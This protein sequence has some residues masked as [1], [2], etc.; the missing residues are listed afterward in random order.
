MP[1]SLQDSQVQID[2]NVLT[3]PWMEV[4][5]VNAKTA[6]CSP[7]D[8]LTRARSISCLTLASPLNQFAAH[9]FLLTLLYWK[10]TKAGG[11]KELRESLLKG[12][13]PADV[14]DAIAAESH[15]FRLFDEQA[16]FL[17]DTSIDA[18]GGDKSCGSLFAEYATGT[19]VAHF[20]HGDDKQMR[21]CL[22]C[23]TLGMLRVVPWTQSGGAGLSPT[24]HGAPPIMT[25]AKGTNLANT[26]GLNLVPLAAKAGEPTWTGDFVPKNKD[27]DIPY[28]DAFTWNARRIRLPLPTDGGVCWGCGASGVATIGAIAYLKNEQ[29]KKRANKQP[30]EW[31]DPAAF[32]SVD[33]A[34]K[35]VKSSKEFLA[36][37]GFDLNGLM[38]EKPRA[39]SIVVAAN[40]GHEGWYLVVPST[41]PANNKTYDHRLVE[42]A[43]VRPEDIR[44]LIRVLNSPIDRRG[45]DGW[46]ELDRHERNQ[47]VRR[48]VQTA[49]RLL[50]A[51]DWA[52]ISAAEFKAMDASPAAFDILSGLF[53]SLRKTV[54]GLPSRNVAWLV[55]KL[56]AAVRPSARAYRA[57]ASYSPLSRLPKRQATELRRVGPTRSRYPLAFPQGHRLEAELRRALDANMRRKI[58]EAIDWP[59]LCQDLGQLIG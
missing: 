52:A 39:E 44:P 17:Q 5:G 36:A 14:L 45:L 6:F 31:Q 30:F 42:L 33:E 35:T 3:S 7:I 16:P 54:R 32:Y 28:L 13:V 38:N 53:W 24:I 41:N 46:T 9:R 51:G 49:V 22:R 1:S 48:F 12:E 15:R 2:W 34:C 26:L 50:S 40:P 18:S 29:T 20:H 23:T 4:M 11:V 8:A 27:S 59:G 19:N 25:V 47:G 58:P 55:L 57:N 21:L 10:A 37:S 43:R 56:M